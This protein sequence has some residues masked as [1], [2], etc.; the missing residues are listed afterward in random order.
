MECNTGPKLIKRA[1]TAALLHWAQ[2]HPINELI[3]PPVLDEDTVDFH[4]A[5]GAYDISKFHVLTPDVLAVIRED[6][7]NTYFPSWMERPPR[8]FGT[9]TH[10][11]LKADQWRT[12]CT[13]SL[14]ITLTRLWGDAPADSKEYV[15]L[16]NFVHLITATDLATRRSMDPDRAK[17]YDN[18]MRRYLQGVL[19]IFSHQLVPNHHLSLHLTAC[20][21]LFGPVHGWWGFPFERYNGILGGLNVNNIAAHIPLTFMDG[22]YAGAELRRLMATYGWPDTVEYR[23]LLDAYRRAFQDTSRASVN[24]QIY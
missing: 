19:D 2:S 17:A 23:D 8:N 10:G 16:H 24:R 12:A 9:A 14:F 20:L 3:L 13:V 6:I 7:S 1:Y 4:I 18:H 15:L 21:L 5:E 11:K 22:F